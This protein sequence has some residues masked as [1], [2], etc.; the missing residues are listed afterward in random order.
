MSKALTT[1][2]ES[3]D[4]SE[5]LLQTL[6]YAAA[7]SPFYQH[8]F[9]D[10]LP[11]ELSNFHRIPFTTKDN[12]AA[13]YHDFLCIPDEKIAEFVSTSGTLGSPVFLALSTGDI[14][15]LAANEAAALSIAGINSQSRIQ[16]LT[17]LDKRFMAGLAYYLGARKLGASVVRTGPGVPEMQWDTLFSLQTDTLIAVPSAILR[18][19]DY[20]DQNGIHP[21]ESSVKRIIC[22]GE[23]IRLPDFTLNSLGKRISGRWNVQLHST[24]ASTEMATAFTECTYGQGG[25]QLPH[26]IHIEILDEAGN[27]VP[28]GEPGELVIT[29]LGVEAM[30]LIRFRT[31]DILTKHSELC[32]CGRYS[33]RLGPVR[34]RLGHM[35]KFK[36]TTF[37]PP[38]IMEVLDS[39]PE[40]H[41]YI[42]EV[43]SDSAGMDRLLVRYSL[44]KSSEDTEAQLIERFKSRLRVTPEVQRENADVLLTLK[45]PE[46]SRKPVVFFDRRN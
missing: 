38:A 31:G 28:D 9:S 27:P 44:N 23:P 20:A 18:M 6:R 35:I 42:I 40:I 25:H 36:G 3:P 22:I 14:E 11:P 32:P 5:L 4:N 39:F 43:F 19:L 2:P 12:L 46:N 34:G 41:H 30:P 29:T 21:N 13:G 26:L 45:F 17:T 37:Y 7:H 8:V 1:Y 33:P 16:I 10:Y 24:Y 15:R